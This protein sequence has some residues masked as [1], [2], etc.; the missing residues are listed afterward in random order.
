MKIL[1]YKNPLKT[2]ALDIAKKIVH[3]FKQK[4][5]DVYCHDIKAAEFG[6]KAVTPE[7]LQHLDITLTLGGDGTILRYYHD[8]PNL[9]IPI[10]GINMGSLGFIADVPETDI[11]PALNAI[12]ER[13]FTVDT[14]LVLEGM[15]ANLEKA[16]AVNEFAFH[17]AQNPSL[18]DLKF[19][20]DGTY[21]STFSADGFIIATPC[22]STAY[23]LSAG[24]PIVSLSLDTCI[25]T[26]ICPHTIT[27]RPI[28]LTPK[29][30]I[31]VEYIGHHL[32]VEI[33]CDGFPIGHLEPK[34][35]YTIKI[36]EKRFHLVRLGN[37][38]YFDTLRQKLGW[39]G[40]LK[41]STL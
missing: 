36:A 16:Y 29:V 25:L 6:A 28:V 17:R 18:V 37:H 2:N 26:P 9:N 32:P 1:L 41:T 20:V 23:S 14:P 39:G 24:G 33:N 30:S 38:D 21:L 3:F 27:N 31:E 40:H 35:K 4:N 34:S 10:L 12:A 8:Y 5:I 13:R 15:G 19:H 22:G 7:I 11:E